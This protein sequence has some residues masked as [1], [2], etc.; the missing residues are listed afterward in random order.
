MTKMLV[1]VAVA[2]KIHEI[3]FVGSALGEPI[4]FIYILVVTGM[5]ER[6]SYGHV[7]GFVDHNMR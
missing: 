7:S 3:C 2:P 5:L 6:R 4:R 1:D